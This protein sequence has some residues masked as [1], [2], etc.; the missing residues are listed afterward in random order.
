MTVRTTAAAILAGGRARR[1]GG[2]DKSRLVIDGHAIIVRQLDILQRVAGEIV[3]IAPDAARFADLG[4]AVH[5]DR[6]PGLGAMGVLYTALDVVRAD[7]VL[8]VGCDQPFLSEPLLA[9]L[10]RRASGGDGAWVRTDRGVEP[11]LACYRRT[12]RD[13][14]KAEIDARRLQINAL[15]AVLRMAEI[16]GPDLARFGSIEDLVMNVNTPDDYARVQYRR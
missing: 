16:A 11:L 9:E 15:G 10:V 3:V 7:N 4:V 2:R 12:G 13:T 1:F 5:A 6:I 14:V 8:V